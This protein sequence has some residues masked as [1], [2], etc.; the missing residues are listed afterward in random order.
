M[1]LDD[2]L[3][4]RV[5]RRAVLATAGGAALSRM[6]PAQL[7]GRSEE[8]DATP[9]GELLERLASSFSVLVPRREEFKWGWHLKVQALSPTNYVHLVS[10]E[11]EPWP[12][13]D[14]PARVLTTQVAFGH[15]SCD[16]FMQ[17]TREDNLSTLVD[18]RRDRN[19]MTIY[20][21]KPWNRSVNNLVHP[22]QEGQNDWEGAR[23]HEMV[24]RPHQIGLEGVTFEQ[25]ARPSR[26]EVYGEQ[27]QMHYWMRGR[28]D[29]F[30]VYTIDPVGEGT[31]TE[32]E[33]GVH[34]HGRYEIVLRKVFPDEDARFEWEVS[35][36][37]HPVLIAHFDYGSGVLSRVDS[38]PRYEPF[39][40]TD[41]PFPAREWY[42][43]IY[44]WLPVGL[45]G[46]RMCGPG[47]EDRRFKVDTMDQKES[48]LDMPRLTSLRDRVPRY[49]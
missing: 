36:E 38:D 6:L 28:S 16:P 23:P 2:E 32:D 27:W 7:Y 43:E 19:A 30:A 22:A 20:H 34:P 48:M 17:W 26:P 29:P 33:L 18:R 21:R 44:A 37:R 47:F 42:S 12:E 46:N 25:M 35:D 13:G 3:G 40:D 39:W 5:S 1:T 10:A 41:S 15:E 45:D 14:D 31:P 24:W 4:G 9:T 49:W 8:S 11:N